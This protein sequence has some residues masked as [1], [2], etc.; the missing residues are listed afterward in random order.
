MTGHHLDYDTIRADAVR[1]VA[2]LMAAA[3]IAAPKSGG[4]LFLAEHRAGHASPAAAIR[5]QHATAERDRI[6]AEALAELRPTAPVVPLAEKLGQSEGT[7][8][9]R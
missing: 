2:K 9:A 8:P 4:Q 6:V 3:A 7:F 1:Q 5:Y